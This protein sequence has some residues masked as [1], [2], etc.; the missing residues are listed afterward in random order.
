MDYYGEF[1]SS[2]LGHAKSLAPNSVKDVSIL[3]KN[4][5]WS[6]LVVLPFNSE[7]NLQLFHCDQLCVYFHFSSS[8]MHDTN[9]IIRR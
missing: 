1:I 8:G 2:E 6:S 3:M 4:E 9:I 5:H 7:G